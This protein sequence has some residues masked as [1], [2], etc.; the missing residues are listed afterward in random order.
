VKIGP[1]DPGIIILRAITK[2]KEINASIIY[3]PVGT[4]GVRVRAKKQAKFLPDVE[5]SLP[6]NLF[7]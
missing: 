4:F 5:Q 2:N 3:S 7:T 1:V 6:F